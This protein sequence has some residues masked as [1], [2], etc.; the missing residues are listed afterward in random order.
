MHMPSPAEL[1]DLRDQGI[2][3]IVSLSANAPDEILMRTLG[4]KHHHFPLPDMSVPDVGFIERFVGI[5]N[6]E[7][8][9]GHSVAVHCGAGLGRTGTLLACYFVNDGLPAREAI[10]RVRRSRPGSVES[11]GQEAAVQRYADFL[12]EKREE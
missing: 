5:L 2:D 11:L 3:T 4:L 7:L 12:A 1:R 8:D 6:H 9:Q 10:E